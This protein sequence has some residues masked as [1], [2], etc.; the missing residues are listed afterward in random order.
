MAKVATGL[1]QF[2]QEFWKRLSGQ[3]LGL[4]ANQASVDH[5]LRNAKDAISALL[6]GQLKILSDP[7]MDSGVKIRTI[8]L[9]QETILIRS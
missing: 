8:W 4:L 5:N 1:D 6:P 9:R 7:N 3:S 2:A